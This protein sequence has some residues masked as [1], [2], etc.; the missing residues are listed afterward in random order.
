MKNIILVLLLSLLSFGYVYSSSLDTIPKY[1]KF[2]SIEI[3]KEV[4]G[5]NYC[6]SKGFS[7]ILL[8]N[9]RMKFYPSI[10]TAIRRNFSL[11]FYYFSLNNDIKIKKRLMPY[12]GLGIKLSVIDDEFVEKDLFFNAGIKLYLSH[13]TYLSIGFNYRLFDLTANNNYLY[14]ESPPENIAYEI[15]DNFCFTFGYICGNKARDFFSYDTDNSPY[16]RIS[17]GLGVKLVNKKSIKNN[18]YYFD[19]NIIST[20]FILLDYLNSYKI[21]ADYTLNTLLSY[22]RLMFWNTKSYALYLE[23]NINFSQEYLDYYDYQNFYFRVKFKLQSAGIFVNNKFEIFRG[24][25]VYFA[26]G[27]EKFI[28]PSEYSI[29]QTATFKYGVDF[30]ITR[31]VG[32]SIG[33]GLRFYKTRVYTDNNITSFMYRNMALSYKF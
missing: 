33:C 25:K 21:R 29:R 16:S 10:Y 4:G 31:N 2:K 32:L 8:E 17:F 19:R 24:L 9:K 27:Y 13:T 23:T 30:D 12:Y 7:Y 3:I 15:F 28:N 11:R 14:R 26:P 1:K 5:V 18:Y 22:Q 20:D 6:F